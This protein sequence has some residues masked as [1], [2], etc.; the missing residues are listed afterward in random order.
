MLAY[1]VYCKDFHTHTRCPFGIVFKSSGPVFF[2]FSTR[3]CLSVCTCVLTVCFCHNGPAGHTHTHVMKAIYKL[4]GVK[5]NEPPQSMTITLIFL[6]FLVFLLKLN[7]RS[8][9]LKSHPQFNTRFP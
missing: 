9:K 4:C 5:T 8:G 6:V 3:L 2:S 7:K 1:V